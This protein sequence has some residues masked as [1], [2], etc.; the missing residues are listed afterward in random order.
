[1]TGC[2]IHCVNSFGAIHYAQH[3]ALAMNDECTCSANFMKKF[4]KVNEK[5][6][7]RGGG[8]GAS[9]A[10]GG[11]GGAASAAAGATAAA[12]GG[13]GA[14]SAA[15]VA[16]RASTKLKVIDANDWLDNK[17]K[18]PRNARQRHNELKSS[19]KKMLVDDHEAFALESTFGHLVETMVTKTLNADTNIN[20]WLCIDVDARDPYETLYGA[21]FVGPSRTVNYWTIEF[22]AT[23]QKKTERPRGILRSLLDKV[24]HD[25]IQQ[26]KGVDLEVADMGKP[27]TAK[28]IALYKGF[29][30]KT[31]EL[32]ESDTPTEGT[33]E[34]MTISIDRLKEGYN[35]PSAA[36][37]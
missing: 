24:F 19:L 6:V 26:K 2:P 32:S 21:V 35:P 20:C 34:Y 27:G 8:G 18:N 31:S 28:L 5:S 25:A 14:A 30:F 3:P 12:G 29:G 36:S 4:G 9:A 7:T 33:K 1:M 23:S 11:G 10:A 22:I 37:K 13:G 17:L 16:D 15:A